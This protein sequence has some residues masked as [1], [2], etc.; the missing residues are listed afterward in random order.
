LQLK[1]YLRLKGILAKV[2]IFKEVKKISDMSMN[3][4]IWEFSFVKVVFNG[5]LI[6]IPPERK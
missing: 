1:K 4:K 6:S 2:Y 3:S 5:R